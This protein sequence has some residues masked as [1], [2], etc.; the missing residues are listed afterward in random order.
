MQDVSKVCQKTVIDPMKKYH[1]EF[2]GISTG[3]QKRDGC[4]ADVNRLE[5]KLQKLQDKEKTA[6]NIAKRDQTKKSLQQVIWTSK[7]H[8]HTNKASFASTCF[9][10]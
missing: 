10:P 4:I 2:S 6:G 5:G 7:S 1:A 9:R 8:K 3:F